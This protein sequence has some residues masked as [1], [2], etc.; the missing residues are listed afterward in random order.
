MTHINTVIEKIHYE[1][2]YCVILGDFNLDLLKFET[3]SG[4]NDFLNILVS[5]YFQPQI[6]Q[7]TRITD[8]SATLIDNIFFNSLEHFTISGNLIYD[9]TN[10]LPNF[11]VV[12]KFSSLPE[13]VKIFKRDYSHFDEQ[14][15]LKDIQSIAWD[16]LFNCNSDPSC[17]FDT[18]YSKISRVY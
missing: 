9:L 18:F 2:K 10:H 1:N 5:S 15:L 12:S 4:T 17:M 11:L 7:P 3:H 6:L 14:A 8:N 16:L 13:N